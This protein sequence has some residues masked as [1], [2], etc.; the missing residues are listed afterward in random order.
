[1]KKLYSFIQTDKEAMDLL[2]F[3]FQISEKPFSK[4]KI[5][6]LAKELLKSPTNNAVTMIP[7]GTRF[8]GFRMYK[9]HFISISVMNLTIIIMASR[10][11]F[12]K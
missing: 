9:K 10:V 12:N 11:I 7:E 1:V 3:L 2:V 6:F 8:L 4:N 5:S